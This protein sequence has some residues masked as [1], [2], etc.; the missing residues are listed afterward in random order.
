MLNYEGKGN[1]LVA[2]VAFCPLF[3]ILYKEKINAPLL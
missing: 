2:C 1:K 3:F